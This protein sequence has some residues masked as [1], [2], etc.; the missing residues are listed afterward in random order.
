MHDITEFTCSVT[1]HPILTIPADIKVVFIDSASQILLLCRSITE[2]GVYMIYWNI[3]K[4][5]CLWEQEM[6]V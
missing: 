1:L 5:L 3:V 4:I 2:T 6:P